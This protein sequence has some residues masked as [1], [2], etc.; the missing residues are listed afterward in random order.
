MTSEKKKMATQKTQKGHEIPVPK[1][2]DFLS[3]LEKAS[4]PDRRSKPARRS[5]KKSKKR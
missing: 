1:R 2:E 5:R 4:K 3:D